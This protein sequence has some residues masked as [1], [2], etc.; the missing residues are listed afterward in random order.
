ME[1][2]TTGCR[3]SCNPFA[4]EREQQRIGEAKKKSIG[5]LSQ[6]TRIKSEKEKKE[7][8]M[9]WYT[10]HTLIRLPTARSTRNGWGLCFSIIRRCEDMYV[11]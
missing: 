10:M 11:L 4:M 9:E 1:T 8:R 3:K 5:F 7:A 6:L 2:N